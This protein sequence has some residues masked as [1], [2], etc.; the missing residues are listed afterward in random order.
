MNVDAIVVG[1]RV[2]GCATA[3]AL[4][5]RGWRVALIERKGRPLGTTVSLPITQPRGL[6]RF[7]DLGLFPVIESVLP[8]LKQ[9]RSYNLRLAFGATIV[10]DAPGAHGFDYG[11]IL[12]RE[13]LDDAL[14]QYVLHA[15]PDN[16]AFYEKTHVDSLLFH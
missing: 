3:F 15:F 7:R 8:H 11:V 6:A 10:G 14:L 4:A 1:A 2:A 9:I 16:I 12:R 13:V 5:T